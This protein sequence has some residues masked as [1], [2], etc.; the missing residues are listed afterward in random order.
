MN[1]YSE[2]KNGEE[3]MT[4]EYI[5]KT[6]IDEDSV[7]TISEHNDIK[8][9]FNGEKFYLCCLLPRTECDKDHRDYITE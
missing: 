7:A 5:Y 1:N 3:T 6:N 4:K 9:Y 8:Y 2:H